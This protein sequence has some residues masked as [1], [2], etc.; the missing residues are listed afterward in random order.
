MLAGHSLSARR[1]PCWL[2][3]GSAQQGGGRGVRR[4]K[5]S[6]EA[7][8]AQLKVPG[9]VLLPDDAKV[10]SLSRRS[11]VTEAWTARC[12][13]SSKPT[14]PAWPKRRLTRGCWDSPVPATETQ[15]TVRAPLL[16]GFLLF[17][18]ATRPIRSS[19]SRTDLPHTA[20]SRP[21]RPPATDEDRIVALFR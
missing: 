2:R 5:P 7:A 14:P 9:L 17:R 13:A 11:R 16:T 12:C 21:G 15:K 18:P 8:A 4:H 20:K 19:P 1:P 6:A 3:G 10:A